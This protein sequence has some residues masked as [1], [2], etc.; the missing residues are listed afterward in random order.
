MSEDLRKK[1]GCLP[2]LP[3][4]YIMMDSS[5][6]VIYVGKAKQ[7]KNRVSSYFHGEHDIKTSTMISKVSDFNVIVAASEF[8]ALVLENSLIKRHKPRYNILLRDD[9]GYPFVRLDANSEYPRFTVVS[10][11]EDDGAKYF[12][13]F[14]GRSVTKDIIDTVC[15]ALLLPTCQRKFR[16][17]SERIALA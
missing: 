1:A 9:K 11:I 7:L 17:T 14:G 2:L 16:G 15:K 8:E 4:V 10:K 12:G 13:P 3:G 5:G 6:E